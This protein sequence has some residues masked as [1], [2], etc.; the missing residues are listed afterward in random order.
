M[1]S[2]FTDGG[3]NV[4]IRVFQWNGPGGDI[5]GSGAINGTLDLIAGTTTRPGRLRRTAFGPGQRSVLR[6]RQHR[7]VSPSPWPFQAKA[8]GS[9]ANEFPIGHFF[10]GGIDLSFLDLEEEC[11]ASFLA[12]TRSSTSVDAVLK[13]F[14]G[15]GFEACESFVVTTPSNATGTAVSTIEKGGSIYDSALITGT[16]SGNAPTGTMDFFICSPA[17]LTGG[18]CATG[19]T[20]VNGTGGTNPAAASRQWPHQ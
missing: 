7:L 18:V 16:G 14:V 15:G 5:A 11:F 9:P 19:G 12:E 1:L 10:E 4:T 17:Q 8:S 20:K 13:D 3:G 2:D 6:H